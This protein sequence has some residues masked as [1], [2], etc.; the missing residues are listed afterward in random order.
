MVFVDGVGGKRFMRGALV[1]HF[2]RLGYAVHCFDYAASSVSLADL[3]ARLLGLLSQ[4]AQGG[5][6][7][8]IGYSFGGVLLRSVLQDADEALLRPQ[9]MVL[10]ASPLVAVRLSKRFRHWRL[11]RL[12]TGDCGQLV[13]D[14]AAMADI[15]IPDIA[16]ACIYGT[17]PWLGPLGLW[18]GFRLPH[19]GMVAADEVSS[20]GVT[21]AIAV[22]ASHGFM[23]GNRDALRAMQQWFE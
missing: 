18:A 19:D 21:C 5:E 15:Q 4:V 17:W 1:R 14:D 16:T 8:A 12:L 22:S 3:R 7:V 6:Y 11:Y 2:S 10:L 9:K 23:P 13:A 20:A